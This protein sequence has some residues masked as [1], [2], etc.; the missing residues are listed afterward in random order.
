[1]KFIFILFIVVS[2]SSFDKN[3]KPHLWWA[4][5]NPNKLEPEIDCSHCP[6][7]CECFPSDGWCD[8]E[9]KELK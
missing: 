4:N 5:I 3:S 2:C 8:C 6:K 1:M 7:E 9:M